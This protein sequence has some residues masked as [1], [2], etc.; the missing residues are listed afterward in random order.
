VILLNTS[1]EEI[2]GHFIGRPGGNFLS[3]MAGAIL[4]VIRLLTL[5]I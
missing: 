5:D 3:G 1:G 4:L 2:L